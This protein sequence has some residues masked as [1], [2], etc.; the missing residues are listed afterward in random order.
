MKKFLVLFLL[1]GS[2]PSVWS[3]P[4]PATRDNPMVLCENEDAA[5]KMQP[6]KV[7]EVVFKFFRPWG[8]P[9][10]PPVHLQAN[11]MA[12]PLR[13][14]PLLVP[15]SN[16]IYIVV[17]TPNFSEAALSIWLIQQG[18]E[19]PLRLEYIMSNQG[20]FTTHLFFTVHEC[21]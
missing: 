15:G 6:L 4:L 8:A 11:D 5:L 19:N 18:A 16:H 3:Q 9:G 2:V 1:L 20:G 14:M 21:H 7:N 17:D 10:V 13:L 12:E